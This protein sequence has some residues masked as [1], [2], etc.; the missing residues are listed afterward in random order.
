MVVKA[1]RQIS[2]GQNGV[3]TFIFPC[4]K[5]TLQY[6]NWGGSSQGLR[7]FL[8][9]KRLVKWAEKY[10]QIQFEVVKKAGHPV[11]KAEYINGLN[12]A[13]CVRNLNVDHVEQ[14]LKLLRESSG[15]QLRHYPKNANVLSLNQSV[16]GV[17]SPLH[18]DP[19]L[20]HR[21]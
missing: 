5:I 6:C 2:V 8:T 17:W 19:A 3:G 11:L 15:A 20:R 9:S 13:I 18:V 14:K 12:K 16:R 21:V 10:P 7:D 4:K 1:L